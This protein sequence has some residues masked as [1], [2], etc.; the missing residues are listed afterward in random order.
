MG[1]GWLLVTAALTVGGQSLIVRRWG[2]SRIRYTREFS[3]ETCS[4]GEQVELVE[5]IANAKKLPVPWLRVESLISAGLEFQS[6]FEMEVSSGEY[7]QNHKSLFSL[8][9]NTKVVRR[10]KVH[11]A[12]R[13]CYR[14]RSA[15]MECGDF[16][17]IRAGNRPLSFEAELLV[18]PKLYPLDELPLPSRSWQGEQLAKRWIVDDPFVT[19]GVREYRYGDAL[20]SVNWK[21]TARTGELQVYK[22]DYTT[23]HKLMLCVNV[24][25][26]DMMW[27]GVTETQRIELG[28]SVAASLIDR[29][30]RVGM[31]VGFAYNG[32]SADTPKESVRVEPGSGTLHTRF[33]MDTLAKLLLERIRPF[34]LFLADEADT[35]ISGRDYLLITPYVSDKVTAAAARLRQNGNTVEFLLTPDVTPG[36]AEKGE[37]PL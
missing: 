17:G 13:G 21:A 31:E 4:E 9:P 12:K 6:R 3:A 37:D 14:L 26:S 10:H 23:D 27:Q 18:Y 15:V 36:G 33:L 19:A 29:F 11:A 16:L 32:A 1:I 30:G 24:E 28:I 7:Y 5:I 20:N 35:G 8:M 22:R 34:E 25:E 2:L